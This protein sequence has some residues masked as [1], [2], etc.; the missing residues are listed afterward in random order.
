MNLSHDKKLLLIIG[1]P[2]VVVGIITAFFNVAKPTMSAP[3]A[4]LALEGQAVTIT[5][6]RLA[7]AKNAIDGTGDLTEDQCN[8]LKT[9]ASKYKSSSDFVSCSSPRFLY[10]ATPDTSNTRVL[11]ISDD[12]YTATFTTDEKI[13]YLI[14]YEFSK[15]VSAGFN[16]YKGRK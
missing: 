3:P 15:E 5:Q 13:D 6:A 4:G 8:Q 14:G 12:K 16:S 9:L 11:T 2:L 7:S 10:L 1:L